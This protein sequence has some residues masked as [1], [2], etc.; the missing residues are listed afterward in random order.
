MLSE[1]RIHKLMRYAWE[2]LLENRVQQEIT[3]FLN[4]IFEDIL[5]IYFMYVK[6]RTAKRTSEKNTCNRTMFVRI[7]LLSLV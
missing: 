2:G 3:M 7:H 6:F 4:E 5:I 1:Q